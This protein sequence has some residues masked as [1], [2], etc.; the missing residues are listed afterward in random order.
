[1]DDGEESLRVKAIFG[2]CLHLGAYE[3]WSMS[4]RCGRRHVGG[5]GGGHGGMVWL[6]WQ[7]Q[8]QVCGKSGMVV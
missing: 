5:K 7:S 3:E 6:R 2:S 4:M 1:M 8:W